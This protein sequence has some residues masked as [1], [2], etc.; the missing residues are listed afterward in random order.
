MKSKAIY[1]LLF[2]IPLTSC[3]SEKCNCPVDEEI[4]EENIQAFKEIEES[5]WTEIGL[6]DYKSFNRDTYR[7]IIF[8]TWMNSEISEYR[9]EN[10]WGKPKISVS[11]Y[12]RIELTKN[13]KLKKVGEA[14]EFVISEDEWA[15]FEKLVTEK[16]FWTMSV[17]SK[18]MYLDGTGWILEAK[19]GIENNCSNR[20]YHIVSR[21]TDSPS[22]FELC[23]KFLKLAS[24]SKKEQDSLLYKS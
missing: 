16:C 1:L 5:S 20:N 3:F 4:I 11:R 13:N 21:V 17:R 22:Y 2:L 10:G 7:L 24:S 9:M 14:K 8:P 19:K 6:E 12:K 23:Y 18:Q 15:E